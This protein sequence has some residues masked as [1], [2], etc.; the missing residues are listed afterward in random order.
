MTIKLFVADIRALL[1]YYA[2]HTIAHKLARLFGDI[3]AIISKQYANIDNKLYIGKY[4]IS[5]IKYIGVLISH[6]NNNYISILYRS[7]IIKT[8]Y[9]TI[10]FN[11]SNLNKYI[12]YYNSYYLEIYRDYI[13]LYS[14]ASGLLS[15]INKYDNS[16]L[17]PIIE[18]RHCTINNK[19]SKE[20]REFII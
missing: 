7:T 11:M 4:I 14:E 16:T 18:N 19:F 5:Y 20:W 12:I 9:I 13:E 15:F 3:P 10:Y 2:S 17:F 6:N 8:G 1:S